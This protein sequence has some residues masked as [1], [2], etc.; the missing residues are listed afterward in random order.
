[1]GK[2]SFPEV[3]QDE[4]KQKDAPCCS[5]LTLFLYRGLDL[6]ELAPALRLELPLK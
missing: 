4:M 3:Q 1:M 5:S 2:H 6:R